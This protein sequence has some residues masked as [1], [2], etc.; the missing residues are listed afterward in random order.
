MKFI[1]KEV[2][3]MLSRLT[4]LI[5]SVLGISVKQRA[6]GAGALSVTLT[7][8][9]RSLVKEIRLHLSAVGGSGTLTVTIDS[10]TNAVYDTILLSQDM[11]SVQ[12]LFWQPTR[13]IELESGD[14]LVV[15]WEN[16]GTKTYG[17]EIL[18]NKI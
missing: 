14:K 7:P 6:T 4:Q 18:Y 13:P 15:S 11:T 17:I 16:A 5:E 10:G 9:E 2:K 1:K 8:A 3:V 12:D